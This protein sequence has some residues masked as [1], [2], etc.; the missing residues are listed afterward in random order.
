M[1]HSPKLTSQLLGVAPF[2]CQ[3]IWLDKVTA[4]ADNVHSPHEPETPSKTVVIAA[5]SNLI[6]Q[7]KGLITTSTITQECNE[8]SESFGCHSSAISSSAIQEDARPTQTTSLRSILGGIAHVALC[9]AWIWYLCARFRACWY[10]TSSTAAM[11]HYE[12]LILLCE[13]VQACPEILQIMEISTS[14]A[15]CRSPRRP[16]LR[17]RGD[18]APMV[19]VFVTYGLSDPFACSTC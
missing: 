10:S 19:H 15:A 4:L 11:C 5:T 18:T 6:Q 14:F 3:R 13:V 1:F 17:L 12:W 7:R 16:C 8:L 9:L 2:S